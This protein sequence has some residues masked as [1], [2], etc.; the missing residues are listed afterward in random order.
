MADAMAAFTKLRKLPEE[1]AAIL[2][3]ALAEGTLVGRA[4]HMTT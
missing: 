4:K 3:R 1:A 2:F